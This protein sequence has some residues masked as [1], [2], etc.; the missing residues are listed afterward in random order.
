[1]PWLQKYREGSTTLDKF[2]SVEAIVYLSAQGVDA[3]MLQ[4]CVLELCG[5]TQGADYRSAQMHV[6]TFSLPCSW[7]KATIYFQI[8]YWV[9]LLG[10]PAPTDSQRGTTCK[11]LHGIDLQ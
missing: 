5:E 11:Q 6:T 8:V 7:R 9:L 3:A 2:I 1:M 4:F 10:I